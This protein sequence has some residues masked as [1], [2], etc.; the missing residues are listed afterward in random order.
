[1]SPLMTLFTNFLLSLEVKE[2]LKLQ[3]FSKRC[4]QECND[5]VLTSSGTRAQCFAPPC[6]TAAF[7]SPAFTELCRVEP[8]PKKKR[9]F[10]DIA[11]FSETGCPA[12]VPLPVT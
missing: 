4:R 12:A 6:T 5:T 8:D 2:F 9:T 7:N 10:G 3:T 11:C 1:M